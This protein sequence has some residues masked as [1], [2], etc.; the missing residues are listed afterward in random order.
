MTNK[1]NELKKEKQTLFLKALKQ[2]P[3]SPIQ[4]KTWAEIQKLTK[5]IEKWKK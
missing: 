1:L 3:N 5:I 2:F 4:L